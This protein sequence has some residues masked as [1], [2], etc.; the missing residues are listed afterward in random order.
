MRLVNSVHLNP[1]TV[2]SIVERGKLKGNERQ[3]EAWWGRQ[4]ICDQYNTMQTTYTVPYVTS[5][6]KA[7]WWH[8][9]STPS[10]SMWTVQSQSWF[11]PQ[12][13][14]EKDVLTVL[15]WPECRCL[16]LCLSVTLGAIWITRRRIVRFAS[17]EWIAMTLRARDLDLKKSRHVTVLCK[18]FLFIILDA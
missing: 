14:F 15:L 10:I 5:K 2:R 13:V 8:W 16:L 17:R 6:S 7:R 12:N 1:S 11:L 3:V 9:T 18:T 4:W